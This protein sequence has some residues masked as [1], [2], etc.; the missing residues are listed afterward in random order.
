M[1]VS[2]NWTRYINQKYGAAA[3]PAPRGID[4]LVDKIGAKLGA[5]DEVIDLGKR[6][7][8]VLAASLVSCHKHP[9]ADNLTVCLIDDGDVVKKVKRN[10]D[11]YVQVVC[12]APNVTPTLDVAWIPPGVAGLDVRNIKGVDSYG[13]LAS[14][15]ELGIGD[16]SDGLLVI[17]EPV[18]PGTAFSKV[19]N[20]D[21]YIIDIENKMFTHRPDLFGM[22]GVAREIA[23]IQGQSFRSPN[24]YKAEASLPKASSRLLNL[25]AKNQIPKLV[26]RFCVL[27]MSDISVEPS[28]L[29]LQSY[30][31]RVGIKPIN[32]IVDATNFLMYESG[33][34]LHAYDYDKLKAKDQ[35][36]GVEMIVRAARKGESLTLLGGKKV[37]LAGGEVVIATREKIIGLGGVMGGAGAEVNEKTCN[38][39]LESG[40][41]DMNL[42]R[43]TA[44]TYGLFTDAATRFTKNQSPLQNSAV[45]SK[46][47]EVIREL[48]GGRVSGKTYDLKLNRVSLPKPLSVEVGIIAVRLGM[49]FSP[50]KVKDLLENVEFKVDIKGSLLN[51]H[52]PF[53][54]TDIAIAEDIVEEV[55]RLYGY[56]NLPQTLPS[57]SLAPA[58]PD[59][60]LSFKSRLREVLVRAGG[61]EVLTYSFIDAD[62][63]KKAGQDV[64]AAF[65]IR[66]AQSPSLQYYRLSLVPSL[67]EKIHPNVK[68]SY[69][70]FGLFEIGKAH[71]RG[72]NDNEKLPAELDRLALVITED[73]FKGASYFTAKAYTDFIL[74]DQLAVS[75]ISYQPLKRT[76]KLPA[77]WQEAAT[78][79]EPVR[80]AAIFAGREFV[81]LVGEPA[82][83][84]RTGLKLPERT[85]QLEL[86]IAVLEELARPAAAYRPLD[87]YPT[88]EQ[89]L[90]LKSPANLSYQQLSD[91]VKSKLD[92]VRRKTNINWQI[93]PLDIYQRAGDYK[94]R[95]TT[96][97]ITF[98][99]P[100]R[101]LTKPEASKIIDELALAAGKTL[102]AERI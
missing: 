96:W 52:I 65:H 11:G 55:G 39:I 84:L 3:D 78:T 76:L 100:G 81:G 20:L 95:Q 66:N 49:D 8:G 33:Q 85:A 38:I 94:F 1:K 4:D 7:K 5:V 99:H 71:V 18:K 40:T 93:S 24:W 35:K 42:T 80:S 97:H 31:A 13:M 91:F 51:I 30:L 32:N 23:G 68:A 17:D 27:A 56:D 29:W 9:T 89:D 73:A 45:L 67:L 59:A 82:M 10:K 60:L 87:K 69:G 22:L 48:A 64:K 101:T 34:P 75:G 14:P 83:S 28:P 19:Y 6:Y 98:T 46:T 21:D 44:T 86:D 15:Q 16:N 43:K 47:V 36:S 63:I 77:G 90:C 70:A 72:V 53:W 74:T 61:N 37:N 54:R 79:F 92:D 58:R 2:L 88:I 57:R 26:P 62:L 102:K 41:F 50:V 12:G 25:I